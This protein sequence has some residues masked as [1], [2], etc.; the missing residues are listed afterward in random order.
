MTQAPS[1]DHPTIPVAEDDELLR[2]NA[3]ELLEESDY[4]GLRRAL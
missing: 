1:A 3:S 2:L 4:I